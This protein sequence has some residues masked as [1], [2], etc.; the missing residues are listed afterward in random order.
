MHDNGIKETREILTYYYLTI[1]KQK[2]DT[3]FIGKNCFKN[4]AQKQIYIKELTIKN[5]KII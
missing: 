1:F 3:T 4:I 5:N 2:S